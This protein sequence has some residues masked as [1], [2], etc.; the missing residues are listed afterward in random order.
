MGEK[1]KCPSINNGS[2]D[3]FV[4]EEY[5]SDELYRAL[6]SERELKCLG[7]TTLVGH[8]LKSSAVCTIYT[9]E[10]KETIN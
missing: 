1:L 9:V 10:L 6:T 3:K 4:D 5:S 8:C 7:W 2:G